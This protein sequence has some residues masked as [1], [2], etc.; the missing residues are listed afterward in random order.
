M[1]NNL[2][3][4]LDPY[5]CYATLIMKITTFLWQSILPFRFYIIL[6]LFTMVIGAIDVSLKPYLTKLIIDRISDH[7]IGGIMPSVLF[8][9]FTLFFVTLSWRL[10]DWCI[11]KYEPEMKNQIATKL[12]GHVSKHSNE[13]FQNNFAGSTTN[14][15]S[16]VVNFVPS[17]VNIIITHFFPNAVSVI[18]ASYALYQIH[19]CFAIGILVWAFIFVMMSV[20]II[21]RFNYLSQNTAGSFSLVIGN[22]VDVVTNISSVRYFNGIDLEVDRVKN[23][24]ITYTNN[25]RKRGWFLLRYHFLEGIAFSVYNSL[26]I[27]LLVYLYEKDLVTLG[28]FAMITAINMQIIDWLWQMSNEIRTFSENWGATSEA[29]KIIYAPIDIKDIKS[30]KLIVQKGEITFQNVCF[31]YR[32]KTSYLFNDLSLTIPS[33]QKVGLVGHSGTGKSTFISLILRLF[34]VESGKI[35]IDDQDIKEITQHSLRSAISIIPQDI[36]LLHRSIMENIGYGRVGATPDEI[37][38]ASKKAHAHDFIMKLPNQYSSTVGERGMKISGGQRQRIAIAR[39]ILKNSPILILDEATNQLDSEI[40]DQI[41]KS[42]T[43]TMKGKTVIV[44]AH[45]LS[46]LLQMDR[47]IVLDQGKIVQDGHHNTLVAQEDG[48]YRKLW[49]MQNGGFLPVDATPLF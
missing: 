12:L 41:Q 42:I 26:C 32:D 38:E 19:Y 2:R 35:M 14:K 3:I 28:D 31:K 24:G 25:F 29:L 13:F 47:I 39:A 40:E 10:Y 36:S 16:N 4:H 11:L 34:D 45:R 37:I 22:V 49:D 5:N 20:F 6:A 23:A 30:N 21:N 15:I 44:I 17:I 9:I 8:Y 1:Q 7:I 43:E 27:V 48:I 33:Q 18:I 46:T